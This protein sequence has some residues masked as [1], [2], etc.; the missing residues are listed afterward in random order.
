MLHQT[1]KEQIKD[2][3]RAKD[4]V[5]LDT[6]RGLDALFLNELIAEKEKSEFLPDDKALLII[7][8]NVKQH[9]DSITQ[10]EAGHRPDLADKE[11]AELVILQ[12]FLPKG[13]SHD[14]IR[15]AVKDKIA[16]LKSVNQ[17]DAKAG[18]PMSVQ[19]GKMT[20]IMMKELGGNA[21]GSEV[22]AIVAEMLKK[23]ME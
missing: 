11:K 21:D 15:E 18:P 8:K 1:I 7:K 19:V 5:R 2:A 16:N 6:L 17:F 14:D 20:G 4:Q 13:L 23:E 9:K 10:F 22:K 12:S 3:M